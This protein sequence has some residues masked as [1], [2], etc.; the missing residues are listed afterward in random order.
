MQKI[1]NPAELRAAIV[2]LELKRDLQREQLKEQF[3]V[4]YESFKTINLF[5]K[6]MIE[7][8]TSPGLMSGL[9]G[10]VV[11]LTQH[12]KHN[13]VEYE[14]TG[15]TTKS[16]FSSL[17]LTQISR[18]IMDNSDSLLLFGTYFIRRLFH[19]NEKKS[20]KDND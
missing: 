3:H 14:S 8:A 11:E 10:T 4:A 1:S 17:I 18:L 19:K 16:I 12:K 9:I 7:I 2:Q 20:K 6:V 15:G 13:H 5:K